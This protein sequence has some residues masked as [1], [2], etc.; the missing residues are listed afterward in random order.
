MRISDWS[1]DVCSSD[2]CMAI[3]RIRGIAMQGDAQI[4][5]IDTP[6]IFVAKRRLERAMVQAAWASVADADVG[7]VLDD[8]ERRQLSAETRQRIA[9]LADAR[10]AAVLVP[11]K[12][13]LV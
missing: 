12:V 13:G 8:A 9:G 2:L 5:F 1:S 3:S 7:L 6:V 11:S 4:V 10:C